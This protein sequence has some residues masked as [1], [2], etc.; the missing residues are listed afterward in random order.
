MGSVLSPVEGPTPCTTTTP[1][2]SPERAHVGAPPHAGECQATLFP[3]VLPTPPVC[4]ARACP[5]RSAARSPRPR[6]DRDRDRT[7]PTATPTPTAPD[8]DP[9]PDPDPHPDPDTP[10]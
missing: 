2:N 9:G 4:L 7:H 3:A 10:I 6:V 5:R 1:P 8:P